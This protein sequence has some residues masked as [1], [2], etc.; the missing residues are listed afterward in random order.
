M[1]PA[2]PSPAVAPDD[3]TLTNRQGMRV[4]ISPLG[5]T[6]TSCVLPLADGARE[7][8]LGSHD[9]AAMLAGASY[10]GASVGRYAGRIAGARFA[11]HALAANQPPHILHGGPQGFS[12]RRWDVV[13]AQAS[14]AGP[15]PANTGCIT[16][17][18]HTGKAPGD[19][20]SGG[21]SPRGPV[22]GG[23]TPGAPSPAGASPQTLHLQL[24]SP[25]GDQGF[26]GNLDAEV[27]YQLDD[28][29]SLTITYLA[30]TDAPTPCNLTSH[31]YFNLNGSDGD[32]GLNQ[33]LRI[34]ASHYQPVGADG[35]PDAPPC[36]V[37]ARS[38]STPAQPDAIPAKPDSIPAQPDA[39]PAQ[40]DSVTATLHVS[41]FDFREGKWIQ[42]DFL[43]DAEQQKVGGY[44]HSFLL[45][46][47][48]TRENPLR[49]AAELRSAD[50]RVR[51]TLGTNQPAL[52]LYTGQYLAGT[53]KRD[54]QSTYANLAGIAL[55]SQYPPDSPSHGHAILQPGT[56][57]RHVI[58]FAFDI[59]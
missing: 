42:R 35:I 31:A 3:V 30:R 44:D 34:H 1:S 13:P 17:T 51:M 48:P 41:A 21:S 22:P 27:I 4:T 56:L 54:G 5:A 6:W 55:E 53:P 43:K 59:G 38:D 32:D 40:P 9:T 57:Y 11:G 25:D 39:I 45:A 28:D 50:G 15:L 19:S 24:H 47:D 18:A 26:P 36:P 14:L 7:V 20:V 52:H 58:R 10:L 37:L 16:T 12:R 8:L 33:W 2:R 29:N 49:L 46:Q 23:S